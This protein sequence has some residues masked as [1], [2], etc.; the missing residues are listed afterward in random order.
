MQ[1]FGMGAASAEPVDAA[2]TKV[3]VEASMDFGKS[4]EYE[5]FWKHEEAEDSGYPRDRRFARPYSADAMKASAHCRVDAPTSTPQTPASSSSRT[6]KSELNMMAETGDKA[7]PDSK[8]AGETRR[9]SKE[10][11]PEGR[12]KSK[13]ASNIKLQNLFGNQKEDCTLGRTSCRSF[14]HGKIIFEETGQTCRY[15]VP[16]RE[17]MHP[18]DLVAALIDPRFGLPKPELIVTVQNMDAKE[19]VD[20]MNKKEAKEKEK[21]EKHV[22]SKRKESRE[23]VDDVVK[24]PTQNDTSK[25]DTDPKHDVKEYNRLVREHMMAICKT[26][27]ECGAWFVGFGQRNAGVGSGAAFEDGISTYLEQF[28]DKEGTIPFLGIGG[29]CNE[30]N[31]EACGCDNMLEKDKFPAWA[32]LITPRGVVHNLLE[33]AYLADL[34]DEPKTHVIYHSVKS[35]H[36]AVHEEITKPAGDETKDVSGE[37]KGNAEENKIHGTGGSDDHKKAVFGHFLFVPWLSHFLVCPDASKKKVLKFLERMVPAVHIVIGGHHQKAIEVACEKS[38]RGQVILLKNTGVLVNQLIAQ[39]NEQTCRGKKDLANKTLLGKR[40]QEDVHSSPQKWQWRPWSGSKLG[41]ANASEDTLIRNLSLDGRFLIYDIH[42]RNLQRVERDLT[43]AL[44]RVGG[45]DE[46]EMGFESSEKERVFSAWAMVLAFEEAARFQWRIACV[47]HYISVLISMSIVATTVIPMSSS[48][49]TGAEIEVGVINVF[50]QLPR[51]RLDQSTLNVIR[52]ICA[53]LPLVSAAMVSTAAYFSPQQSYLQLKAAAINVRSLIYMYRARVCDFE[54]ST[55]LFHRLQCRG[56]LLAMDQCSSRNKIPDS[57]E[58]SD[59]SAQEIG[60][61]QNFS[62]TLTN[63]TSRESETAYEQRRPRER[64]ADALA[65]IHMTL[66]SGSTR[67]FSPRVNEDAN[68]VNYIKDEVYRMFNAGPKEKAKRKRCCRDRTRSGNLSSTSVFPAP[69]ANHEGNV[70]DTKIDDDC[71]SLITAEGYK[72]MFVDRLLVHF[73]KEA[74]FLRCA[75]SM[76]KLLSITCTL[77][78]GILSIMGLNEWMPLALALAASIEATAQFHQ[79]PTR[80]AANR[81]SQEGLERLVHWWNGLSMVERRKASGKRFLVTETDA[82][83][84]Q[85]QSAV[86]GVKLNLKALPTSEERGSEGD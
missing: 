19:A 67:R 39:I 45:D 25:K 20:Q 80:L 2:I 7:T 55:S 16:P 69:A 79:I 46:F 42:K 81:Y 37:P 51:I 12:G 4:L 34:G 50:G 1:G 10:A 49:E 75:A 18:E 52:L 70:A 66:T 23:D 78:T 8:G 30:A 33:D 14:R 41:E 83:V 86:Y 85:W 26:S 3:A 76:T 60:S 27:I 65:A 47:C 53:V 35:A 68:G 9:K 6:Q 74:P 57:N 11:P 59:N 73:L 36:K 61:K 64:F 32:T 62:H 56:K 72:T 82:I 40:G 71:W 77:L 44:T 43:R 48:A 31:Y 63:A 17:D 38:M 29:P 84:A 5:N 13:E 24:T 22:S 58:G 54:P 28:P 15:L 21:K